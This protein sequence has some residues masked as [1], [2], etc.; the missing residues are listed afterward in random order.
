VR[1]LA[2]PHRRSRSGLI[3]G[4]LFVVSLALVLLS[5]TEVA[6]SLQQGSAR[7]LDP[8]RG[9]VAGV[10]SGVADI[11]EV[12]GDIGRLRTEN[13]SLR[14]AL[15]GAEQRLAELEEAARENA[16]LRALLG[17]R[18]ILAWE[19][20]PAQV[21][22][23]GTSTLSWEVSID[24]GLDDGVRG[25]MAVVGAAEGGGALAG[26]VIEASADRAVVRLIVDPRAAA[27]VRDQQT[28]ALGLVRGQPGGQLVMSQVALTDEVAVGDT[29][30][31]AGLEIEGVAVSQYPRGLLVGTVTATETDANGLTR[32]VFVRPALDPRTVDWL[33]VVL[34]TT[35]D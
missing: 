15:A 9:V 1:G 32:T 17:L 29:I 14:G 18:Q 12:L 19:L 13:D 3:W 5:G 30:V 16:R 27:V 21:T 6:R 4:I 34:S 35:V 25:G 20:L 8:M 22:T 28:E 2:G 26:S 33:M 23:T 24:V 10:A 11:G 7:L 31:T